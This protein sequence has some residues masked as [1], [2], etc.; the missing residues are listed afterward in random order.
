[1]FHARLFAETA[2][3]R[4]QYFQ[5]TRQGLRKPTPPLGAQP[6]LDGN[7]AVDRP[8]IVQFCANEPDE[9]LAAARYVEPYCDAI[10]LNLGCPQ[11]IARKGYYGAFLQEDWDL[12]YKLIN[13]LHNELSI[14]VT[15][16][17]RILET[18]EK[19]LAYAQKILS[20]GASII[21]VHGRRRE[22][23][24]HNT[25]IADWSYLRYL[26]D[27][28]PPDTVIFSNGNILNHAD[29]ESC[30]QTTGVDGV[31]SAEGNLSDP[32]IFAEP[33]AVGEDNPEY[34][35]G[36]DGQG[37][38]RVDAVFRRYLDI[39]HRHVLEREPPSRPLLF[40]PSHSS[41]QLSS[42]L[43][44]DLEE[45]STQPPRKKQKREKNH[46]HEKGQKFMSPNLKAI[47]GHLFNMLRKVV[48]KHTDIRDALATCRLGDIDAFERVLQMVENAV[49]RAITEYE[50]N[51]ESPAPAI[52]KEEAAGNHEQSDESS[53]SSAATV[54]K[55]SRPWWVCQP[56]I[57]PLPSEAYKIGAMQL[58]KKELAKLEA[59][60][61]HASNTVPAS[62]QAAQQTV[63][64]APSDLTTELPR[65]A[66]VCG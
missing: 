48:A 13:T 38:Y 61:K 14:P 43:S 36:K 10:D 64:E 56:Y 46:K 63:E 6:F 30:F 23:K 12:I 50:A 27:N 22:Q 1:M 15:A 3:N 44:D 20:A 40:V 37:G 55:Y 21:T 18:K 7:P 25:G 45:A 47:Q 54:A 8:L 5:P 62:S 35:Q 4:D 39:I 41:D 49:A 34:W 9:L 65:E 11:G 2:K 60:A 19:T 32:T 26:R 17:L 33:P 51:A 58:S 52:G 31:M 24:A 53:S 29:I 28:L 42:F 59:Q 66:L 57:R 16:K